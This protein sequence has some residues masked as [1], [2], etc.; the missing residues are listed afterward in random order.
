MIY[1]NSDYLESPE[2][3]EIKNYK[4][5]LQVESHIN[6]CP[7]SLKIADV[8]VFNGMNYDKNRT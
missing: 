1:S 5:L 7:S 2:R 3:P 8:D 4:K 6:K